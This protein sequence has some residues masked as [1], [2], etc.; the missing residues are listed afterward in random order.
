MRVQLIVPDST[1]IKPEIFARLMSAS[2]ATFA[3]FFCVP[4]ALGIIGYIVP[5][6]IGARGVALPRLNQLSVWLYIAGGLVLYTSFIY[7]PG[8]GGV[9]GLAPLSDTVFNPGRGMDNWIMGVGLATARLRPLRDQSDR[10]AAQHARA[11]E[12]PGGGCRCSAGPRR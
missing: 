7:T 10:H 8:E 3:V 4:L 2:G 6:Q 9:L 11:R 1:L 5:L 12:W